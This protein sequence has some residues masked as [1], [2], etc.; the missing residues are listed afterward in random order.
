MLIAVWWGL[1]EKPMMSGVAAEMTEPGHVIIQMEQQKRAHTRATKR[2][3]ARA[4]RS[5]RH[6]AT[7]L[8]LFVAFRVA[9]G[10]RGCL[11]EC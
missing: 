7:L 10:T 8:V 6:I 5:K 11:L 1:L 9:C 2:E 4:A 3:S